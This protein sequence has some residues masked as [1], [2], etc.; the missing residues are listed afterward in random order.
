MF[1]LREVYAGVDSLVCIINLLIDPVAKVLTRQDRANELRI[2][3]GK[4]R[5]FNLETIIMKSYT[6]AG[7]IILILID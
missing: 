6:C 2:L 3:A 5:F 7:L 1:G 4:V